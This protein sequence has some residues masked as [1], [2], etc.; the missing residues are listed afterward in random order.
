MIKHVTYAAL[1]HV[2]LNNQVLFQQWRVEQYK[3]FCIF[4]S[5]L[6][7][8]S[9]R[10]EPP[11]VMFTSIMDNSTQNTTLETSEKLQNTPNEITVFHTLEGVDTNFSNTIPLPLPDTGAI[12][13]IRSFMKRPLIVATGAW[14]TAQTFNTD[15]FDIDFFSQLIG[16]AMWNDKIKG[17]RYL[18]YTAVVKVIFNPSPF[19]S[20]AVYVWWN[21]VPVLLRA[22]D[23]LPLNGMHT[24]DLIAK[25]Q[26]PGTMYVCGEDSIQITV[27]YVAPTLSIDKLVTSRWD[28]G[29]IVGTI[30]GAL[31]TGTGASTV[32]YT[33]YLHF[34]DLDLYG[35]FVPN[36]FAA[37]GGGKR[38]PSRRIGST[39]E[40]ESPA[41]PISSMLNTGTAVFNSL[42]DIPF[43]SAFCKPAAWVTTA[44]AGAASAVGWSKPDLQSPSSYMN[45][46]FHHG[47]ANASGVN[48]SDKLSVMGD[49]FLTVN[50][51]ISFRQEDEMNINFLKKQW[52]I[53]NRFNFLN[54]NIH[55]DL[56][57]TVELAPSR[58]MST[59]TLPLT[60]GTQT[61]F[62]ATPIGFLGDL[63]QYWRGGLEW[64]F[65]VLKTGYH[66]GTISISYTPRGVATNIADTQYLH[67]DI[68]DIQ[69]G[70]DICFTTPYVAAEPWK[71]SDEDV[72]SLHVHVITPL[73]FPDTVSNTVEFLVYVRG[74]EDSEFAVPKT[75]PLRPVYVTNGIDVEETGTIC[76]GGVGSTKQRSIE[77]ASAEFCIGEKI[78]SLSSLLK[79]SVPMYLSTDAPATFTWSQS[80]YIQ[81]Y[82][83]G[84]AFFS[85]VAGVYSSLQTHLVGDYYS[86][87]AYLYLLGRG[88]LRIRVA[89]PATSTG[90]ISA[91]L[92]V[93]SLTDNFTQ[94]VASLNDTDR[95]TVAAIPA[96]F[97]QTTS[98]SGTSVQVPFY[99]K[100][101]A[102]SPTTLTGL[103]K[104][105]YSLVVRHQTDPTPTFVMRSTAD[106]FYFSSFLGIPTLIQ[107]FS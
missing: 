57:Y 34:E 3:L 16:N 45:K 30:A 43:L 92:T 24:R 103:Y 29:S 90:L 102:C 60:V 33:V 35:P 32:N 87:F 42:S 21:P 6:Q 93:P 46:N 70:T 51:G 10:H 94:G 98:E 97:H 59:F 65:V 49:N 48:L 39:S 26:K 38:S 107:N 54:T 28:S 31:R 58:M 50:T 23:L 88:S 53:I 36:G 79:R 20:G 85:Q 41:P 74:A 72:G 9:Q 66:A 71:N 68:I 25:S 75:D 4:V 83:A 11:P 96:T 17:F 55:G 8:I 63:F 91:A 101:M 67:K 76:T 22:T 82:H 69:E 40:E 62:N 12:A 99:N 80:F 2:I 47:S 18:K 81:P 14:S 13:D 100:N 15:L 64:R 19:H 52:S 73:R 95:S 104:P 61:I 86:R 56:L 78:L 89:H 5:N 77:S 105:N 7:S 37:S 106:D 1:N 84:A 44:L 27:P